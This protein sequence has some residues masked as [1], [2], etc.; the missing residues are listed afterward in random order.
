MQLSARRRIKL[1]GAV[2]SRFPI[3]IY[4][5]NIY[6]ML[7]AP[8][9]AE[10]LPNVNTLRIADPTFVFFLMATGLPTHRPKIGSCLVVWVRSCAGV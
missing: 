9:G 2:L 3:D 1:N 5:M 4:D 6:I 10:T 7:A 8:V